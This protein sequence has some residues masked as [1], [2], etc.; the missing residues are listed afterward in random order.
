MLIQEGVTENIVMHVGAFCFGD[1]VVVAFLVGD[2]AQERM[3]IDIPEV[4][5]NRNED[6]TG[7]LGEHD[8]HLL[9]VGWFYIVQLKLLQLIQDL[10]EST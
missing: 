7:V 10:N 1:C 3:T 2:V 9:R 4:A 8:R 5:V 6:G